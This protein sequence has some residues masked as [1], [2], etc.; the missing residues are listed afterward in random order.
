MNGIYD[1]EFWSVCDMLD[2]QFPRTQNSVEAW[3]RRLKVVVGKKNAGVYKLIGD[4]AKELIVAKTAIDK[5]KSGEIPKRNKKN[6]LRNKKLKNVIKNK[7]IMDHYDFLK[8]IAI[9][10]SL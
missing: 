1:I 3:H 9:N 6:E 7:G 4:L 8:S 10:L 2:Q 5:I